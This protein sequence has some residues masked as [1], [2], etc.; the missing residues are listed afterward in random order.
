MGSIGIAP[1][2]CIGARYVNVSGACK[3]RG[4]ADLRCAG[5]PV[6]LRR[7]GNRARRTGIEPALRACS[8]GAARGYQ[9]LLI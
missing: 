1:A 5:C 7:P 3:P 8:C 6:K 9:E 4:N 2:G